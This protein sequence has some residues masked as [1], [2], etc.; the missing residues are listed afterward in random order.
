MSEKIKKAIEIFKTQLSEAKGKFHPMISGTNSNVVE[1][2]TDFIFTKLFTANIIIKKGCE[3]VMVQTFQGYFQEDGRF[4]SDN[5]LSQI[6][7]MRKAIVNI[8]VDEPIAEIKTDSQ[9][10]KEALQ[11]LYDGLKEIDDEPFDEEFDAII[12]Q[13]FTIGKELD[14]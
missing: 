11:C 1:F 12:K 2:F 5:L 14:L 9:K 13:G 7:V 6:P 10:Q 3:C 8:L 4:I